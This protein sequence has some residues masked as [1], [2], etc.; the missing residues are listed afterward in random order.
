MLITTMTYDDVDNDNDNDNGNDE[1]LEILFVLF[2]FC[3]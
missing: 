1:R 3:T 2:F